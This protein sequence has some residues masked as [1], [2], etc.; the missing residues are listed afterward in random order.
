MLKTVNRP[1]HKPEPGHGSLKPRACIGCRGRISSRREPIN[2]CSTHDAEY[3]SVHRFSS[4]KILAM[5]EASIYVQVCS[6]AL[7]IVDIVVVVCDP[8]MEIHN[9]TLMVYLMPWQHHQLFAQS[10]RNFHHAMGQTNGPANIRPTT[11]RGQKGNRALTT[12]TTSIKLIRIDN[13]ETA[14]KTQ[15]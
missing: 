1:R 14:S 10:G 9:A 4:S 2:Q 13:A 3:M 5:S 7:P 6:Y 11:Q 8:T 12:R 15:K